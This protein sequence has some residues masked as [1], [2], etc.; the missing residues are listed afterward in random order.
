MWSSTERDLLQMELRVDYKSR[1]KGVPDEGLPAPEFSL[2]ARDLISMEDKFLRGYQGSTVTVYLKDKEIYRVG[3][4]DYLALLLAI[5]DKRRPD[6]V[7][8][9]PKEDSRREIPKD[10]GE[11]NDHSCHVVICLTPSLP[12]GHGYRA[13]IEQVPLF[14]PQYVHRFVRHVFKFV[15]MSNPRTIPHSAGVRKEG[16]FEEIPVSLKTEFR[17]VPS[18]ELVR[19]LQNGVLAAIELRRE[20]RGRTRFD[21]GQFTVDKRSTL[22]VEPADRRNPP[23]IM[24]VIKSVCA[25][26]G[27]R[28]FETATVR[29]KVDGRPFSAKFD[30]DTAAVAE[31]RYIKRLTV[32]LKD[33]LPASCVKI[34]AHLARSMISWIS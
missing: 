26:A 25:T 8:T 14:S 30:C 12:G 6:H 33:P 16:K 13:A 10:T 11:G 34:D 18:A 7:L 29:W 24:D 28:H 23:P 27:E 4:S 21:E 1:R 20:E 22:I 3:G 2:Y 15:S 17:A 9:N 31:N 19:D 5:S 32:D